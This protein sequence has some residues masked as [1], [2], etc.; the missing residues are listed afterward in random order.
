ML[1]GADRYE[2][3]VDEYLKDNP[4][5]AVKKVDLKLAKN[6]RDEKSGKIT[7]AVLYD[8]PLRFGK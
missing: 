2:S 6:F 1:E 7:A 8:T 4:D 3:Q 5:K